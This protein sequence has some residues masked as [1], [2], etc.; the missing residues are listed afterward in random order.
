M[1]ILVLNGSPKG[2]ESVTMQYIN[3][4]IKNSCNCEFKVNNI[5]QEINKIENDK[6]YFEKIMKDVISADGIIWAFP[7]YYCTVH[8]NYKRFIELIWERSK[9]ACFKDKYA[10]ALSTSIHFF[11]NTAHD[12]INEICDDL[13]MKYTEYFS[14]KMYD[15][16]EKKNR[17]TLL[18]F[19]ENFF[20]SIKNKT[21][22]AK[23]FKPL[24]YKMPEYR[25][26]PVKQKIDNSSKKIVILTD[27]YERDT[28]LGKMIR[29]FS[30]QFKNP[31]EIVNISEIKIKGACLGC[32]NCGFDNHRVY[33]GRDDIEPVYINKIFPADILVIAGAIKDRYLSSRWKKFTDRGFFKT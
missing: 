30:D 19:A 11:D 20:S 4:I 6:E 31:V 3:Y 13:N 12:Y 23:R 28:N 25:P 26:E 32:V 17:K 33:S 27:A 21:A 8:S 15:A 14:A 24:N 1:K 18:I 7:L 5:A 29:Q 16:A 10:C 2:K 9:E 22:T